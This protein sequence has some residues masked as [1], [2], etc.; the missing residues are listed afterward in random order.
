MQVEQLNR[1]IRRVICVELAGAV[2]NLI[3]IVVDVISNCFR[4]Q[5]KGE[6]RNEKVDGKDVELPIEFRLHEALPFR[7]EEIDED[8][9]E[10]VQVLVFILKDIL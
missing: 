5:S 1:C 4:S 6:Q 7:F 9:F 10:E 8:A 2:S 3:D